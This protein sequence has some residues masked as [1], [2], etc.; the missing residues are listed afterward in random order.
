MS[1]FSN[2]E[3]LRL[4]QVAKNTQIAEA[5]ARLEQKNKE[6]AREHLLRM[7]C[8]LTRLSTK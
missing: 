1:N 7:Q 5:K 4:V 2:M 8:L 6:A 3:N